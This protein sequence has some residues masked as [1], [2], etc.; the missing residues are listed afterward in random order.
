MT[1]REQYEKETK[2]KA[3]Q[4]YFDTK[5]NSF[6]CYTDEYANWLE[7]KVN[8]AEKLGYASPA[9]QGV[10]NGGR[11]EEIISWFISAIWEATAFSI[12]EDYINTIDVQKWI[13][14]YYKKGLTP[15]QAMIEHN[16]VYK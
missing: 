13:E 8:R 15:Y 4:R 6:I 16:S 12:E 5:R 1:L 9:S 3:T 14:C 11:N 10:Q 7:E 2:K